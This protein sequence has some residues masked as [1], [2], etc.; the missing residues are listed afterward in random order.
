LSRD[1]KAENREFRDKFE[2]LR[3]T[4]DKST[5]QVE[6]LIRRRPIESIGIFFFAGLLLG[7][8]IGFVANRED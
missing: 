3:D 1:K 7:L 6:K 4:A 2:A 8:M 5:A